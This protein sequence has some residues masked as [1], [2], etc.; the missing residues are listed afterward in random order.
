MS[1]L[2]SLFFFCLLE[3]EV[4]VEVVVVVVAPSFLE[5]FVDE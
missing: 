4:K 5:I 3:M 2:V 1:G